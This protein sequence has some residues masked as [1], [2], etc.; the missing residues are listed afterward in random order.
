MAPIFTKWEVHSKLWN[1][2]NKHQ[3][4]ADFNRL[5]SAE[6]W[7]IEH[8]KVPTVRDLGDSPSTRRVLR[9]HREDFETLVVE[10]NRVMR[11]LRMF[12][13]KTSADGEPS[14]VGFHGIAV[15]MLGLRAS[16]IRLDEHFNLDGH[17]STFGD[18]SRSGDH[19]RLSLTMV[20]SD[21]K[22]RVARELWCV[23]HR[24]AVAIDVLVRCADE[25]PEPLAETPT[26]LAKPLFNTIGR[27]ARDEILPMPETLSDLMR[28][29][30]AP[31]VEDDW[32]RRLEQVGSRAIQWQIDTNRLIVDSRMIGK[33][34]WLFSRQEEQWV[35]FHDGIQSICIA[36]IDAPRPSHPHPDGE[37]GNL[38]H[39]TIRDESL[40]RKQHA[41]ATVAGEALYL[42]S[43]RTAAV[44]Y[45]L[46]L[47]S[48][49]TVDEEKLKR[50]VKRLK[51]KVDYDQYKR[52]S[53]AT[54]PFNMRTSD[55]RRFAF[56][57][58]LLDWLKSATWK[59]RSK[60]RK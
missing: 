42:D 17:V 8:G 4:E 24:Q 7:C 51:R 9:E 29:R 21:D 44:V 59:G 38:P 58:E 50:L 3:S 32:K 45:R 1:P 53:G 18:L 5:L 23:L 40:R 15:E 14:S 54:H 16:D 37:Q 12:S 47:R 25:L 13:V 35:S 52:V 30:I 28:N 2:V 19:M 55:R 60:R 33:T 46:P 27:V 20:H 34:L 43:P 22:E 36:D 39:T 31:L 6:A 56:Q 10:T 41:F 26:S 57:F 11:C 48:D 49:N